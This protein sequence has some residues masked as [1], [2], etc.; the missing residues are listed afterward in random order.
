LF[1]RNRG[2]GREPTAQDSVDVRFNISDPVTRRY[3]STVAAR[4]PAPVTFEFEVTNMEKRVSI[5]FLLG[6]LGALLFLDQADA[7]ESCRVTVAEIEK[8]ASYMDAVVSK[9]RAEPGCARAY[10]LAEVC[11][12]GTSGDNQLADIVQSKCEPSF[13]PAASA[14]TRAAYRTA[15]AKRDRIAERNE[16][17][18]YMSFAAICRAGAARDFAKARSSR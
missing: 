14:K 12:F 3:S 9:V 4:H 10:H 17:T 8:A 2:P 7:A 5:G 13:L 15:L 18:M 1:L 16:G 11:Q 6:A